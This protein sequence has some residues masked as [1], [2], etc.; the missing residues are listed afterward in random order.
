MAYFREMGAAQ[1]RKLAWPHKG[2]EKVV[3]SVYVGH[4]KY[5]I[6]SISVHVYS[7]LGIKFGHYRK[8]HELRTMRSGMMASSFSVCGSYD[9]LS[10]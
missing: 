7:H 6:Q 1:K 5:A 4:H 10:L 2:L 8:S 9:T 3:S